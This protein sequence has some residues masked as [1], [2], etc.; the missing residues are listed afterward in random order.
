[1]ETRVLAMEDVHFLCPGT[2]EHALCSVGLSIR[3]GLPLS[4]GYL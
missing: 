3:I 1:M 4:I 2:I